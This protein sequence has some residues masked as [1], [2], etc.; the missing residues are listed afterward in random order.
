MGQILAKLQET[1]RLQEG[2]YLEIRE[3]LTKI[4]T[5]LVTIA[6][7][8]ADMGKTMWEPVVSAHQKKGIW[9]AIAKEVG[10]L[11]VF[12]WRSIHCR[13]RWEDLRRWA[14]KTAEPQLGLAFQRGRG[15]HRSMTPVMFRILAVAYPELD[16]C[17]K[18][19]QQPREGEY[20]I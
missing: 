16:G 8:L 1:Q 12:D 6:G 9:R 15:A 19:L 13:E 11:G 14:K 18:A 20:R 17:L 5:I 7:V 3:D 10:T 4:Y 2:L